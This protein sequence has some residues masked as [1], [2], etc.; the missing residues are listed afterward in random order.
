M[1]SKSGPKGTQNVIQK[2]TVQNYKKSANFGTKMFSKITQKRG[3]GWVQNGPKQ[4]LV[5]RGTQDRLRWP[6]VAQDSPKLAQKG[7]QDDPKLAQD[8]FK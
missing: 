1:G 6:Q 8:G 4:L 5:P 2:M 3:S 7:S